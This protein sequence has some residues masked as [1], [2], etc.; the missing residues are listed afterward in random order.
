V[1]DE[2]AVRERMRRLADAGDYAGALSEYASLETRLHAELQVTPERE[3]Q[4]LLD[5]LRRHA[6]P[7]LGQG[8]PR[9]DA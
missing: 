2:A 8:R 7:P 4:R 3:T 5:E 9:G 1:I 6:P